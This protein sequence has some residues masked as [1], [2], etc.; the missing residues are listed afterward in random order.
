[1]LQ[2]CAHVSGHYL[3]LLQVACLSMLVGCQ[4]LGMAWCCTCSSPGCHELFLTSA[5]AC[6]FTADPRLQVPQQPKSEGSPSGLVLGFM[7]QMQQQ[8][9]AHQQQVRP[10]TV[11]KRIAV[12][13]PA[14]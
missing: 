6:G 10:M 1:M 11:Q 2:P 14:R 12:S 5:T 9:E 4:E 8:Q 13:V 3:S 7:R